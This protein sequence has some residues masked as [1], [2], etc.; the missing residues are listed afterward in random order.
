MYS[1]VTFALDPS[2]NNIRPLIGSQLSLMGT[3]IFLF[4]G[5]VAFFIKPDGSNL[6][7]D[8][9]KKEAIKEEIIEESPELEALD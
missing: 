7:Y 6:T 4:A 9:I 2:M 8:D 1:V 3:G 5:A